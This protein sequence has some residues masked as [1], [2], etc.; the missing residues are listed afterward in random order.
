MRAR[1]D[2]AL[3]LLKTMLVASVVIPVT[4]F[5]YASWINYQNAV[6]RADEELATSLNIL[7]Q[8]A[9]GIFQS[10]DLTFTAVDAILGDLTDEQIKASDQT[11]HQQL[12][13]LEKSVKAIDAILVADRNGHT[14]VSSALFPVPAGLDIADRDYF[15]AQKKRDAGTYVGAASR[16]LVRQE[17]FFGISRRRPLRDGQFNG[18]IMI[19]VTP[20][21][22]F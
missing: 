2:A 13:K 12:G 21:S 8:Q 14:I 9:S 11:L 10:V 3:R 4:I 7:S 20:K 5:A 17:A 15:L 6:A 1:R 16:S 19:S 18:I 22:V